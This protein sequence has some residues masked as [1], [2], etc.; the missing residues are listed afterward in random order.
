MLLPIEGATPWTDSFDAADRT[1]ITVSPSLTPS[2][3]NSGPALALDPGLGWRPR[4]EALGELKSGAMKLIVATDVAAR[5][6]DVKGAGAREVRSP[7]GKGG[8]DGRKREKRASGWWVIHQES[9][10]FYMIQRVLLF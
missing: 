9:S 4:P 7:E 2:S 8:R 1:G 5:G 3:A 6:I 10:G